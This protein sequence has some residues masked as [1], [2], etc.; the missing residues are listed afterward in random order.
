MAADAGGVTRERGAT[1]RSRIGLVSVIALTACMVLAVA[2]GV[3]SPAASA[4]TV[5]TPLTQ[6]LSG[7]VGAAVTPTVPP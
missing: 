1:N 2:T 7:V 6:N 5:I 4:V 3:I